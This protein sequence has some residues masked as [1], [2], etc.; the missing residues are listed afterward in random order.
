M[1]FGEYELSPSLIGLSPLPQ[2]H[3][4]AFQRLSVRTSI[5]RYPDF[6][7]AWGRSHGFASSASDSTPCSDSP[8]LRL[9]GSCRLTSPDTETRRFIMQKARRHPRKGAPTACRR[10]VSGTIS[11]FCPKCF[12]PFPHG[13]GSLSVSREY[14]ALPDGPGRFTRDSTCP[15]LLRIPLRGGALRVPGFHRLR[16][17]FPAASARAPSSDNAVLQPRPR[18][19]ADGLG[20]VPGRSPLLGESFL[21]SFPAGTKMFQFPA[22]ASRN[23]AG[24]HPVRMPGSPIRKPADQRSPAPPRGLSQLVTSFIASESLGIRRTPL[25]CFFWRG[26]QQKGA[27][28]SFFASTPPPETGRGSCRTSC[29]RPQAQ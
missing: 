9:R 4:E 11:L 12:S 1:H 25:S 6:I 28:Q 2:A 13:T 29:Q 22:L 27:A 16:R 15:A 21:F 24:R 19:N 10:T 17:G 5:R 8:S 23:T 7:L 14:S 26:P 3:P 18:R 20:I